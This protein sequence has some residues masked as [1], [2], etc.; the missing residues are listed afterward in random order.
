MKIH[1]EISLRNF[2]FWSGAKDRVCDLTPEQL[3]EVEDI[4]EDLYPEGMSDTEVNDLFWHDFETISEWLGLPT[5]TERELDAWWRDFDDQLKSDVVDFYLNE[6]DDELE[7]NETSCRNTWA[8]GMYDYWSELS[9]D[10]KWEV[11]KDNE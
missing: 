6:D 2:E 8:S 4:L 7:Y 3:D 5:M 11:Y 1:S 9:Y 10:E